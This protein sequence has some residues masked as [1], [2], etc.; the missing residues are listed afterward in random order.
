[1]ADPIIEH[2]DKQALLMLFTLYNTSS[3]QVRL[4]LSLPL[5]E[6]FQKGKYA[7]LFLFSALL[8][9]HLTQK[10]ELCRNLRRWQRRVV[11]VA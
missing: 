1:M 6:I 3:P 7:S 9:N 4:K 2:P 5:L 10:M 11:I 8:G